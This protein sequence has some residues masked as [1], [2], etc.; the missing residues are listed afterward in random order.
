MAHT[1]ADTLSWPFFDDSHRRFATDIAATIAPPTQGD[2]R[3][4]GES[5]PDCA[6]VDG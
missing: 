3:V 5:R 1:L 6:I 2:A 4:T